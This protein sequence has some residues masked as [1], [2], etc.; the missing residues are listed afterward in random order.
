[1]PG[2]ISGRRQGN[3]KLKGGYD[4]SATA[5]EKENDFH[6][7]GEKRGGKGYSGTRNT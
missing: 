7:R 5:K 3:K 6:V 4:S 1:M 2:P